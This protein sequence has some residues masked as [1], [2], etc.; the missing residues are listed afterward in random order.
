MRRKTYRIPKFKNDAEAAVF[1]DTHDSIKYLSE[2]KSASLTFPKPRHKVV[3]DLKEKQW[4]TL[5]RLAHRH[6]TSFSN[7]LEKLLLEKLAA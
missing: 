7:L 4:Q 2:T 6:K 3:L 5:Q 1:W